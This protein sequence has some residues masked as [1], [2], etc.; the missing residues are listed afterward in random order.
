MIVCCRKVAVLVSFLFTAFC[1]SSQ[2]QIK[3]ERWRIFELI[4][5]GPAT[6]NP[7]TDVNLYAEFSRQDKKISADGFYDGDGRYLIRFMPVDEGEWTYTTKSSVAEL[8][9]QSGK[10]TCLPA[11]RTNHGP[12]R[13]K[14]DYHFEYADG[15]KYLPFGTTS[16]AWV[17]QGDS[18]ANTTVKTLSGGYFNKMRMC[19]FPKWYEYNRNEPLLYPFEGKP[20]K[21]WDYGRF[22][23]AFFRNIEKRVAQ[24]DSL[25]IQADLILFHSYDKWGFSRMGPAEDG[26][27][28][29]YL[30]ARLSAYKN[31]WW[32][33]ANEY[34]LVDSK[35]ID[36]WNRIIAAVSANDPY[37]HLLSIHQATRMFDHSRNSI[38]HVS[39]Q[40]EN[41]QEANTVR[42]KYRKPVIYDE[43]RYEGNIRI[44]W[45]NITAEEMVNKFYLGF[46]HGGYVGHGETYTTEKILRTS[47][48]SNDI[49]WWSKGGVLRGKSH[50]RIR[51]MRGILE[52][53]P[54]SLEPAAIIRP[55]EM[56][57]GAV[58]YQDEYFL[59]YFN[60]DQPRAAELSLPDHIYSIELVDTWNMTI[61]KLEGKYSGTSLVE[62][63]QKPGMLLRIIRDKKDVNQSKR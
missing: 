63:P 44:P 34:D 58:G 14:G 61:R 45:G 32:S 42:E 17:H 41:T 38:T 62:L 27:Y 21:S 30:V 39:I 35:N 7:Y 60:M 33:I 22:N 25:G 15:S 49:L 29:K 19:I 11:D 5:K 12:V 51:F 56:P 10:F 20:E 36:D 52:A 50:T 28:I 46:S 54:G 9:N 4:L 16:Y 55:R 13:V 57:Y 43:C 2:E 18:L 31:V 40:N 6:G 48:S 3:V 24:L 59:V 47:S 1:V 23:P 37:R 8:N 26:R 53:A